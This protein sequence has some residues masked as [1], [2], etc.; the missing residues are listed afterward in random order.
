M[1]MVTV[2]EKTGFWGCKSSRE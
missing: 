2:E 1:I